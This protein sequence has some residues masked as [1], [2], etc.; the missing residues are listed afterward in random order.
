MQPD[1][2]KFVQL[3]APYWQ[4]YASNWTMLGYQIPPGCHLVTED[5]NLTD[6]CEPDAFVTPPGMSL[7]LSISHCQACIPEEGGMKWSYMYWMLSNMLGL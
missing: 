2:V 1:P 5:S 4:D 3:T 6:Y 7:N